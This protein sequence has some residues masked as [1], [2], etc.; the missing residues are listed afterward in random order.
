MTALICVFICFVLL[1]A[2]LITKAFAHAANVFQADYFLDLVRLKYLSN[3]GMAFSIFSKNSDAMIAVTVLTV[4][5]IIGIAVLFFTAFKHNTPARVAL[6]VI[7]AG[8]VGNLVDR[9]C[10]G[11]VRDFIDVRTFLFI[12]GYT[13]NIADIYIVIG[14]I[15][16]VIILLFIGKSAAFPI[17]KK[18]REEAKAQDAI[19]RERK[20]NKKK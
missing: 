11:Y 12:P 19:K 18:W 15:A 9:L 1:A 14:A 20:A 17:T 16:L 2:D 3:S 8:A 5:M 10:L 13:C 4:V 6:A 7:E